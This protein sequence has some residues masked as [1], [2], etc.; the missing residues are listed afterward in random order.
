M[1]DREFPASR[2]EGP[3]AAQ[4]MPTLANRVALQASRS[5]YPLTGLHIDHL[6]GL[7]RDKPELAT[8]DVSTFILP[9]TQDKST[10]LCS[11]STSSM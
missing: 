3:A 6:R 10:A 8:M 7:V 11:T 2:E 1:R 9:S 5:A 4:T